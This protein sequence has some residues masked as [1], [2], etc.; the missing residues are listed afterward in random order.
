MKLTYR[1]IQYDEKDRN[2]SISA[3]IADKEII[4]R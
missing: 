2:S 3:G 4:Y 1:G